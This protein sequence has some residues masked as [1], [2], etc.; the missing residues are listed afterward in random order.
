MSIRNLARLFNPRSIALI[1]ASDRP[2]SVGAVVARNLLRGGFAG[3]IM[4]VNPH[5]PAI[6]SVLTY[7]DVASLPLAPD[8]AVIATPPETV[9]GLIAELG[10][11]GCRAAVVLTAGF[12]EGDAAR[13]KQLRQSVLDAAKPH[14]LRLVGPNCLGVAVPGI[15]LNATFAH[16]APLAGDVACI[17][18][19]GAVAT[20]LIDWATRRGIGFSH[21]VSLGDMADVDVGDMLDYLAADPAVRSILVYIEG[22]TSAR[23]F[24]SAARSAARVKPLIVV[25]SGRFAASAQAASSHTGALAGADQV[26]DTA[27]R[28]AGMLRVLTLDE[29]FAALETLSHGR[30]LTGDRLAVLTNGGGL[31]VLATD[32][33][34]GKGGRLAVLDPSTL[35]ALDQI[36]PP[37]WSHG[38]PVDILGDAPGARYAAALERIVLDREIDGCLILNCPQAV[39]SSVEAAD[40][41]LASLERIDLRARAKIFVSWLGDGAAQ[42][43]RERFAKAGVPS[44]DTPEHAVAG[45]MHMLEFRRNQQLLMR[46]PPSVPHEFEADH[47]AA[48]AI[49]DTARAAGQAWLDEADSK[50]LLAAYGIPVNRV[51]RVAT[52]EAVGAAAAEIGP[53]VALK[54]LS[55]DILHKSDVGGVVLDLKG[56]DAA[57]AAARAMLDTL[58]GVQ[59]DARIDGF[60]VEEMVHRA[61]AA[62]LILGIAADPSFGPVVLFGHGGTKVGI[63]ED[64]ALALAPL[65]MVLAHDLIRSTRVHRRLAGFRNVPAADVE[66][67]ALTLVKLSQMAADL[68]EIYE[69][70]INPL[71]ADKD[72]VIAL[73]ARI[74]LDDPAKRPCF[75]ILPYPSDC[76]SELTLPDGT[77]LA[78]RPIRPEDAPRLE[79]NFRR[80]RPEDIHSRFFGAMSALPPTLL[81]RLTQLDYDREIALAALPRPG[82]GAEE[83]DGYGIVRLAA[84]PDNDKAEFALIVRSDWHGRGLGGALMRLILDYARR[85][86]IRTVWGTVLHQNTAMIKLVRSLGFSIKLDD[87]PSA[88]HAEIRLQ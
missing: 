29:M 73:D 5:H 52:V 74:R 67:V 38:N 81:A 68:P 78:I 60:T 16:I 15:G 36:L 42:G 86:G 69:L 30:T 56:P 31:G 32:A 33:L 62:E 76:E 1:G 41:V 55:P 4:P 27:F 47:T 6:E 43:A 7:P 19:S 50:K 77:V 17:S 45:F 8:L 75:A 66:A 88:V 14:L 48:R 34:I 87:D 3:P 24:M 83:D 22:I 82:E 44:Y 26:Y 53:C 25:K 21:V 65:D 39:A 35:A 71:L 57:I 54:I 70:D 20:T 9:P 63:V 58:Q 40:A 37:T 59:P 51:R 61:D 2:H 23:K 80:T 46:V 85:R 84:D 11:K 49:V 12:G 18:Q 13:G 28:R 72:G 10:A 79:R 64:T